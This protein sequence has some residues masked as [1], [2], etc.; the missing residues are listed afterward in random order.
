MCRRPTANTT[1]SSKG[2]V[3]LLGCGMCAPPLIFYLDKHDYTVICASR[4]VEKTKKVIAGLKHAKAVALDVEAE[5]GWEELDKLTPQADCVVSLLPY[6]HHVAAAKIALKYNK[7]FCT[8]SYISDDMEKL[9]EEAEAKGLVLLNECGV[10]PGLDHASAQKIIDEVH[11]KG[12][13]ILSFTSVCGGL[14]APKDNNNPIG[15]KLSWS[16]RGVLMAGRNDATYYKN[17]EKVVTP[18]KM[19]YDP[20]V[21]MLD[22]TDG[23]EY[24]WYPNRDSTKYAQIYGIPEAKTLIRGTFRNRGWCAILQFL[25]EYGFNSMEEQDFKGQKVKQFTM[26]LLKG[27]KG[28]DAK[29]EAKK[30]GASAT[31]VKQLEWMG[32]FS[33]E[34]IDSKITTALDVVCKLWQDRMMYAK[35]E[36][37][38]ILMKHTFEVEWNGRA[39]KRETI[40]STL[41]DLGRQDKGGQSSMARTVS[42][43]V[44]CLIRATLDGTMK[45]RGLLRPTSPELYNMLLTEMEKEDIRFVETRQPTTFW[46]R[47]EVKPGEERTPVTPAAAKELIK[48]G[49]KMVVEKSETRCFIDKEYEAVG[50]ELV[51]PGSW[52]DAGYAP[53][54]LGLKELPRDGSRRG[55]HIFFAHCYKEQ[56]DWKETI[57]PFVKENGL[58]WDMEFLEDDEGR[59]VAAFGKP[60]GQVGMALAILRWCHNTLGQDTPQLQ[61]WGT[62]ENMIKA[63][64]ALLAKAKAKAGH[65]PSVLVLGALGRCGAGACHIAE[66]V[67][68][69][70]I[71]RWDLAETSKG[72]PFPELL[73]HDLLVNAIYLKGPIKGGAFL[74]MPQIKAKGKDRVLTVFCD[75]SCDLSNPHNP[76]P[77]DKKG[78]TLFKPV[79]RLIKEDAKAGTKLFDF[80]GI[81]HLP[82]LV[83]V[84]S[85]VNYCEALLPYLK[86]LGASPDGP[87][88]PVWKRAEGYFY[89]HA[90]KL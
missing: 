22:K 90:K 5:G 60:A 17:G 7:H 28:G 26:N 81:D 18:G 27:K 25:A 62:V 77:L 39:A 46:M 47:H 40:T 52:K 67:G 63:L 16:P 49:I 23:I 74:D 88:H 85:S 4:T 56:A 68:L 70:K 31:M 89:A 15:Y 43:P 61:S 78:N 53:I 69:T 45:A 71:T 34:T 65:V 57:S 80:I 6:I 29:A 82:S 8:T 33:D 87:D 30:L 58:I 44:A 24:E 83:P 59:R 13:K 2:T 19:L 11:S 64:Q 48:A 14:P 9:G 41:I 35:G 1:M 32:L 73:E 84:D 75:V 66:A 76:F 54:I 42:L 3:L 12:G 86:G 36:Q 72:P 10:D 51:E 37:D 50:C 21:Y 20:S 38:M 79:T 55:R